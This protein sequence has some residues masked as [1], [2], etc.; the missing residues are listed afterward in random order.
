[1]SK[2]NNMKNVINNSTTYLQQTIN[3]LMDTG[4]DNDFITEKFNEIRIFVNRILFDTKKKDKVAILVGINYSNVNK[5]D[6]TK[7][8][9][10]ELNGCITDVLNIHKRLLEDGY[11]NIKILTDDDKVKGDKVLTTKNNIMY[12]LYKL[13]EYET[14]EIFIYFSG[15]G[16][17]ID[18]TSK[19]ESDNKD[20]C[21]L[22]SD[23]RLIKDNEI[24]NLLSKISKNTKVRC[25]FDCC[26][27]GTIGDLKYNYNFDNYDNIIEN[28]ESNIDS[29][30]IIISG[31]SDNK[32]SYESYNL[33]GKKEFGGACTGAFLNCKYKGNILNLIESMN[34]FLKENNFN[35]NIHLSSSNKITE[36]TTFL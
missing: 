33:F 18:S 19:N 7:T 10:L 28:T 25:I 27:S 21:Y 32:V 9:N 13:T 23:L 3:K 34:N 6:D 16:V 30:I 35:Q 29:D 15:H 26:H 36:N 2:K 31:C 17:S 24:H 11:R 14:D 4:I 12:E 1:M 22:T 20:E 5:E 8:N